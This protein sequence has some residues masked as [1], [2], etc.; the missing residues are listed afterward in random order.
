M[1]GD[2][3]S[4]RRY[5]L[6]LSVSARNILNHTNAGAPI[7]NLTSPFFGESIATA[8]GFGPDRAQAGNRRMEFQ[9]R[10]SF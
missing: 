4:A 10:F 9:L 3:G 5:N 2:S 8:G 1:F 6:T 7:G